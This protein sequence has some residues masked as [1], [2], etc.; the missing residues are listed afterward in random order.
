MLKI[1]NEQSEER[2]VGVTI[3]YQKKTIDGNKHAAITERI[4]LSSRQ[5][6]HK[7][8]KKLKEN[9][10]YCEIIAGTHAWWQGGREATRQPWKRS[11]ESSSLRPLRICDNQLY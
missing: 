2:P 6:Q 7:F 9:V 3:V 4:L 10:V 11:Q 5:N 1:V 8:D